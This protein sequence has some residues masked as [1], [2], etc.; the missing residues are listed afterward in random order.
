MTPVTL[1][2]VLLLAFLHAGVTGAPV[3]ESAVLVS[4]SKA[5]VSSESAA[6]AS[7]A[8]FE[9]P[10]FEVPMRLTPFGWERIHPLVDTTGRRWSASA[11]SAS[12]WIRQSPQ[13]LASN[14]E[15]EER[16]RD[17]LLSPATM[18]EQELSHQRIRTATTLPM[19]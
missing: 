15:D 19:V 6:A 8:D 17:R 1:L 16:R 3:A 11:S 2:P 4:P 14:E 9:L 10:P 5:S 12:S 13:G 7:A 18:V